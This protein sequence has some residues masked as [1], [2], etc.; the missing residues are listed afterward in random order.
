MLQVVLIICSLVIHDPMHLFRATL[1]DGQLP[2]IK[3]TLQRFQNPA[4]AKTYG[5]RYNALIIGTSMAENFSSSEVKNKLGV[6]AMNLAMSGAKLDEMLLL[7]SYTFSKN[8][9]IKTVIWGVQ[10]DHIFAKKEI[11]SEEDG[12]PTYLYNDNT[13]DDIL[14]Y[15]GKRCFLKPQT[16]AEDRLW[17]WYDIYKN[18]GH[19]TRSHYFETA[20]KFITATAKKESLFKSRIPAISKMLVAHPDVTFYIFIPPR[21]A[22]LLKKNAD[23]YYA[24]INAFSKLLNHPNARLFDFTQMRTLTMDISR[25]KDVGHYD[26]AGNSDMVAA[27]ASNTFRLT[28]ETLEK[29]LQNILQY[30]QATLAEFG[31]TEEDIATYCTSQK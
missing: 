6:R 12:F 31:I 26:A 9:Q 10:P 20:C 8:P 23:K 15:V 7:L 14:A 17:Y 16:V 4:I 18:M 3:M 21:S 19:F 27:F 22:L 5:S 24:G 1:P 13:F 25:Y 30:K 28:H 11:P 29:S 2:Q